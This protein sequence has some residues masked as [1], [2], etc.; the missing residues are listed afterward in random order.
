[1][2]DWKSRVSQGA[3]LLHVTSNY[4]R[5]IQNTH[6]SV[7]SLTKIDE[8]EGRLSG[9]IFLGV[10]VLAIRRGW[11]LLTSRQSQEN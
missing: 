6:S 8:T 11:L 7:V 10:G 2:K 3:N 1:M 9:L 4:V 5:T